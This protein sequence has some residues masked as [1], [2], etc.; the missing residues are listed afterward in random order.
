MVDVVIRDEKVTLMEVRSHVGLSDVS[1]FVRKAKLYE[2][3]TGRKADRLL[4]VI[5][6]WTLGP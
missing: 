6:S 1:A 5:R 3:K 4:I 2:M